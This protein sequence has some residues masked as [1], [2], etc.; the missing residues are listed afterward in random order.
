MENNSISLYGSLCLSDIPKELISTG[1]NGKKY[2]NISIR[3]RREP[4]QWGH[5]HNVLVDVPKEQRAEGSK[6]IYIGNLKASAPKPQQNE[7]TKDLPF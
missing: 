6:P 3:Q 4:S 7:T 1:N 2:L 5:T